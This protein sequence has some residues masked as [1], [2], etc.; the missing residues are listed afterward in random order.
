MKKSK[1]YLLDSNVL[2]ALAT[3]EHSLNARAGAWFRQGHRFATCPITQGALFRFH[4]RAGVDATAESAKHLLAAISAL[5]RHEFW[6][7]DVS[8]LDLPTQGILGHK[9]V[10]D[11]YLVLLAQSRGG[12]VATMDQALASLHPGTTLI[13]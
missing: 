1:V 4:L 7:D 3:P 2:I 8:Y 10:T 9:Q 5:P 6:P 11:A 13:P 12:S